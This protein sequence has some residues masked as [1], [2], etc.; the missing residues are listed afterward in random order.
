MENNS[1][2]EADIVKELQE[3]IRIYA[4]AINGDR[5]FPDPRTGLKPVARRILYMM[6]I[7]NK[8]SNKPHTKSARIVGDVM[9]RLHPHGRD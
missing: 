8:N 2:M 3:D 7:T 6:S 4:N 1:I 5:A 9:G